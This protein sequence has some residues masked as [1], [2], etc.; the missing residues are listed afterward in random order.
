L[1]FDIVRLLVER[2]V[3]LVAEAAFQHH[4]WAPNLEPLF[5]IADVKI[6]QC[7]ADLAIA[8]ERVE[9]RGGSRP[10]HADD[11]VIA[12]GA[13]YFTAFQRLALEVPAIEVDTSDGYDPPLEYVADLARLTGEYELFH[14]VPMRPRRDGK[15]GMELD[16]EW[17]RARR[18]EAAATE[19]RAQALA[20]TLVGL[21]EA[22]ALARIE[23]GGCV[24]RLVSRD[25]QGRWITLDRRF[26]RI[27]VAL[28]GDKVV[29]AEVY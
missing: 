24:M 14:G 27:N 19:R 2:G 11:A 3:T 9:G 26:N 21:D 29:S 7:H 8:R 4:V 10:A 16:P 6:V 17:Y 18:E 25:G 15:Q 20:G 22:S 1:F 5:A 12:R 13:D 28:A 23:E